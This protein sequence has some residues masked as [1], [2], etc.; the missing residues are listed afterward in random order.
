[1]PKIDRAIQIKILECLADFYP[2]RAPDDLREQLVALSNNDERA[3]LANLAYL[4]EEGCI[5]PNC[6]SRALGLRDPIFSFGLLTITNIGQNIL[7]GDGGLA[8]LRNTV[9]VRFHADAISTIEGLIL[10]S[11]I[12][13]NKKSSL[14]A[15]L[16]ELPFSATEHLMKKLLDAA[17]LR[18]PEAL[19]LIEKALL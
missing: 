13:Q 15:K 11:G 18:L 17:V 1:M 4:H 8:A 16:R 6:K 12:D 19:Q 14:V 3:L 9:T 7:Q 2:S 5:N 10:N